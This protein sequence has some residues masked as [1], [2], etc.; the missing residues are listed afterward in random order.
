M[1]GESTAGNHGNLDRPPSY[2][3]HGD[4][5]DRHDGE[6][7]LSSNL[8]GGYGHTHRNDPGQSRRKS[9]FTESEGDHRMSSA[10]SVTFSDTNEEI[11]IESVPRAIEYDDDDDD[12]EDDN[13]SKKSVTFSEDLVT[14][15]RFFSKKNI[16]TKPILISTALGLCAV[17]LGSVVLR[18]R[19]KE[20]E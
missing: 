2:G 20:A 19:K 8:S 11:D 4:K 5:V 12:F 10:R 1:E 16:P 17:I 13:S 7:N 18:G 9:S 15:V 14:E 3:N 6:R